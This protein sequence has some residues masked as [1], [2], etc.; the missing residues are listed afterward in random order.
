M[1]PLSRAATSIGDG[2]EIVLFV[3][4]HAVAALLRRYVP[5][6]LKITDSQLQRLQRTTDAIDEPSLSL[7]SLMKMANELR[8]SKAEA[9]GG[10]S[11]RNTQHSAG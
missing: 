11:Q 8:S 10:D 5:T 7:S 9:A 4:E 2:E 1:S 6:G 3:S